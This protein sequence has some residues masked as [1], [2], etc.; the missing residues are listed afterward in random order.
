[1]SIWLTPLI[2]LPGVAL[3]ILSTSARYSRLHD[4]VD[5]IVSKGVRPH[6]GMRVLIRRAQLFRNA[7]ILLYACVVLFSLGS[8]LG[9]IAESSGSVADWVVLSLVICGIVC[10]LLASVMLVYESSLSFRTI[11][12]HRRDIEERS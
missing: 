3:L 11:D 1:M 8:L 9:A 10:L 6:S 4:E 12:Q 5:G 7:L 2:L